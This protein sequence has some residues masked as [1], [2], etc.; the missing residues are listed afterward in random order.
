MDGILQVSMW[1][2][3]ALGGLNLCPLR[4]PVIDV[5][6]GNEEPWYM[7]NHRSKPVEPIH[8]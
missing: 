3:E 6:G 5:F 2:L 4:D 7:G 8:F 1:S